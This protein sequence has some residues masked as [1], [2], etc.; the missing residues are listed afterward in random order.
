MTRCQLPLSPT[1]TTEGFTYV[2]A[3][4]HLCQKILLYVNNDSNSQPDF[5]QIIANTID[6]ENIRLQ[7]LPNMRVKE[8][9]KTVQDRIMQF[10]YILHLSYQYYVALLF[11]EEKLRA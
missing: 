3:M 9:C 1:A 6:V 5:D 2:E 7:V 10:G 11:G 8:A 4:Y